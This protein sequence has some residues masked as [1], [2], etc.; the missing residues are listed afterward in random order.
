MYHFKHL[1]PVQFPHP[2]TGEMIFGFVY[3]NPEK[4]VDLTKVFYGHG[5]Y[6]FCPMGANEDTF[7]EKLWCKPAEASELPKHTQAIRERMSQRFLFKKGMCVAIRDDGSNEVYGRVVKGGRDT[8][9]VASGLT[10]YDVAAYFVD[11]DELPNF[12]S[13][14][15][16]YEVTD[17][18]IVTGHDDSEPMVAKIRAGKD[19]IGHASDDGWGAGIMV[20]N[21]PKASPEAFEAF[22]STVNDVARKATNGA[23]M[24]SSVTDLWVH[25][26]WYFRP[27]RQ[28]FENYM[29]GFAKRR[30][31]A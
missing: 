27:T 28:S 4:K 7:F 10:V 17:Y 2:K 13:P 24:Y 15:D 3:M 31:S 12:N 14:L 5:E 29:A 16:L 19:V 20:E 6:F 21:D 26:A 22:V 23:K 11:H 30:L 9:K 1:D 8:I 18:K 25:W